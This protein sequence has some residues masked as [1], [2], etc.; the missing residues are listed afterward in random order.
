[1]ARIEP[2]NTLAMNRTVREAFE[3]HLQ[4]FDGGMSNMKATLAYSDKAFSV[5][6]G[7]Y[8]LYAQVSDILGSRSAYLY[9]Y[10]IS[11]AS[12]C[13]LCST[14]FRKIIID[15]G[16]DPAALRLTDEEKS[17]V[18]FGS[19]IARFQ[20]NIADH[21]YQPISS[22]YSKPE[23]VLLCAF[24]GQMIAANI[25]NNVVETELDTDLTHYVPVIRSMW[26]NA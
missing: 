12:D 2:L 7:W 1:M 14:F 23:Q 6:M 26:Q 15:A 17:L 18:E 19:S 9:A 11:N 4:S 10:S 21:V 13:P 8:D 16:E 3:E 25:F 20:G 24:A 22:K 5:Y